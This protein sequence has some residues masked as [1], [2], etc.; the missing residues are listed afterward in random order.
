[1]WRRTGKQAL[2]VAMAAAL[3][4][5]TLAAL[6][7][8]QDRIWRDSETLWTH[9]LAV[10][11][12]FVA[13]ENM[14]G[15]LMD[16]GDCLW[17]ADYFRQAI[18]MKPAA[19]SAHLGLGGA[20]LGLGRAGEAASEFEIVLRL[21][22]SRDFAENGLASAL[23]L[24][25]KLDEAIDHYREALKINPGYEDARRNLGQALARKNQRLLR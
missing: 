8:R 7:W 5:L 10:E 4:I 25:G 11:P 15:L 2:L 18:A 9:A 1:L 13:Y 23:A 24:Q 21:G 19:P 16:R 22:Q 14:G 3:A 20:F 6:T 17:A 12:S